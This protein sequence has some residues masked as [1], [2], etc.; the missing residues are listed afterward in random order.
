MN[1]QR[2]GDSLQAEPLTVLFEVE[3]LDKGGLEIVVFNLASSM[4]R[5][6]F[7]PVVVCTESGGA[8]ADRLQKQGIAVEVLG[9]E[10]EKAYHVLLDRYNVDLVFTHH[11]FLGTP[12]AHR[13]NV[14]VLHALHN[15]YFWFQTDVLSVIREQ[16]PFV[17]AYIAVSDLVKEYIADRFKIDRR[18]ITVIPNGLDVSALEK[19]AALTTRRVRKDWGLDEQDIVLLNVAAINPVKNQNLILEAVADLKEDLPQL[20]VLMVGKILN[21]SYDAYLKQKIQWLGLEE[22][23]KFIEFTD[24]IH[25]LY[26]LANAFVLPSFIEGWSLAAMEAY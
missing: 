26:E 17:Q 5:T 6:L 25:E 12:L 19:H 2:A 13:M 9:P 24:R 21:P 11:S 16:D 4:D 10:K 14:P 3:N 22:K 23:V 8:I 7:R 1:T 18:K 15:M 20:K